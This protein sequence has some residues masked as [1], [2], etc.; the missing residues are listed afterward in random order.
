MLSWLGNIA[1]YSRIFGANGDND[2][3]F[4]Y[5]P[6]SVHFSDLRLILGHSQTFGN[7]GANADNE[8]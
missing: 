7:F 5:G 6:A 4:F 1:E 2:I 8:I 3:C